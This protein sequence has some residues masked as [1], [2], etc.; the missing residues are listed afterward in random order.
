MNLDGAYRAEGTSGA[1]V[2]IR[3]AEV[4][5]AWSRRLTYLTSP[6]HAE[7]VACRLRLV[8]A[9]RL[10]WKEILVESDCSVL[11]A[12]LH[13]QTHAPTEVSRIIDDCRAFMNIYV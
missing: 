8:E 7:I 2:V 5:A 9:L 11:V 1:S 10:G 6:L 3:D 12:A 13:Q 4:K